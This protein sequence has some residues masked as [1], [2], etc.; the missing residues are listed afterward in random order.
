MPTLYCTILYPGVTSS[1]QA[2]LSH[3]EDPTRMGAA[4]AL[5]SLLKWLPEE[6]AAPVIA[7]L[8]ADEGGEWELRH[9]KSTVVFIVLQVAFYGSYYIFIP[10]PFRGLFVIFGP[11][12]AQCS[13]C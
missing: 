12:I 7:D 8:L 1:L 13:V 5:G 2:L 10:T 3:S 6:E 9:G 11:L 4:A